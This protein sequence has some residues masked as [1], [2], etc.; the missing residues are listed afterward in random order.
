MLII[1][2][3]ELSDLCRPASMRDT[4][5]VAKDE[6]KVRQRLLAKDYVSIKEIDNLMEERMYIA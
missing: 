4:I 2:P 1:W 5:Y 6:E 3:F